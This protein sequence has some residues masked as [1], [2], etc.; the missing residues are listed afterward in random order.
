MDNHS[1][2]SIIGNEKP[3]KQNMIPGIMFL[4]IVSRE[5]YSIVYK[6]YIDFG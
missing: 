4:F 1:P 3:Y 5:K 2:S 6:V